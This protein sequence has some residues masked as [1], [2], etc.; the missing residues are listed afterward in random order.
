MKKVLSWV[1]IIFVFFS[2]NGYSQRKGI[3]GA[4]KD[5]LVFVPEKFPVTRGE[6]PV[7]HSLIDFMPK[8][9]SQGQIGSCVSWS[10]VYGAMTIAKRIENSDFEEIPFSPIRAHSAYRL[11]Y[12]SLCEIYSKKK[13][14]ARDPNSWY[15]YFSNCE[16]GA[17]PNEYLNRIKNYGC[18]KMEFQENLYICYLSPSHSTFYP[19]RIYD[20]SYI[21]ANEVLDLKKALLENS[22]IIITIDY[23]Y[24][25]CWADDQ[26]FKDGV[27]DGL[28]KG[29][30]TGGHAMLIV[31]YDD[32]KAG[33]AFHIV[34]SWGDDFGQNGTFWIKYSDINKLD[35]A[36]RIIL[37]PSKNKDLKNVSYP[38]SLVDG[39]TM[40][41]GSESTAIFDLKG[42]FS[43]ISTIE[44]LSY[45]LDIQNKKLV[46]LNNLAM[47]KTS[48]DKRHLVGISDKGR[49]IVL[50]SN[51][52]R[53]F[54]IQL[55]LNNSESQKKVIEL[56]EN[57]KVKSL[58]LYADY[59]D[60]EE[61][62][63]LQVAFITEDN[64][65][66][67]WFPNN[68]KL[69]EV[70]KS[71]L[72][73]KNESPK[74]LFFNER[75]NSIISLKENGNLFSYN[76]QINEKTKFKQ[77]TF[78]NSLENYFPLNEDQ[79]MFSNSSS[80]YV[81]NLSSQKESGM[82][83]AIK[84]KFLNLGSPIAYSSNFENESKVSTALSSNYGGI[85]YAVGNNVFNWRKYSSHD[86]LNFESST[87]IVK[88]KL[89]SKENSLLIQSS[90][91]IILYDLSKKTVLREYKSIS[92]LIDVTEGGILIAKDKEG[93]LIEIDLKWQY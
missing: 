59:Y 46:E 35:D 57:I 88:M 62:K 79:I 49:K 50:Y 76:I 1:F 9:K 10:S 77:L 93:K 47:V 63:G 29:A 32:K 20:Y 30:V 43:I 13:G 3:G 11:Y 8:I 67:L 78:T 56:P 83:T 54:L 58:H 21:N 69:K 71:S 44:N 65:A 42:N 41:K 89:Y 48:S 33:G 19:D 81:L 5:T 53:D 38:S 55:G 27:W 31:G 61:D 7:S 15:C 34:N 52:N 28:N 51:S 14:L 25:R 12:D 90:N 26:Y 80:S 82:L 60:W 23:Y 6:L 37:D 86:L 91:S 70:L 64:K 40:T 68:G 87:P 92:E 4:L 24:D 73:F 36:F 17:Y 74:F 84:T 16:R 22:P 45:L 66:F 18:P 39:P 75:G 85:Y 72:F 2:H